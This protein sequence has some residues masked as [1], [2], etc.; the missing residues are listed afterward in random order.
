MY[1]VGRPGASDELQA[2]PASARQSNDLVK[3]PVE[4]FFELKVTLIV[5][6]YLAYH[7]FPPIWP[8]RHS[9][10]NRYR[11]SHRPR[12]SRDRRWNEVALSKSR[13][14]TTTA[15]GL[16]DKAS[17]KASECVVTISC[18]R[19]AA[20]DRRRPSKL[21]RPIARRRDA[22]LAPVPPCR[23]GAAGW[24]AE[25]QPSSTRT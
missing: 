13:S 2:A 9:S 23:S 24:R 11:S 8:F 7:R 17:I 15:S 6:A 18:E 14:Q 20:S 22:I 21:R 25:G 3:E 10:P 19:S 12:P 5:D 4:S 1:G 16:P